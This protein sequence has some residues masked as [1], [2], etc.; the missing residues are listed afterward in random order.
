MQRKVFLNKTPKSGGTHSYPRLLLWAALGLMVLV[1]LTPLLTRKPSHKTAARHPAATH[2]GTVFAKI[3]KASSKE[4][5]ESANQAMQLA[6]MKPPV[7]QQQQDA[8]QAEPAPA[9]TSQQAEGSTANAGGQAAA[10]MSA[11]QP[12]PE[13]SPAPVSSSAERA[14]DGSADRTTTAPAAAADEKQPVKVA[15]SDAAAPAPP[16]PA[17]G[18]PAAAAA[19]LQAAQKAPGQATPSKPSASLQQS[20]P[21]KPAAPAG[22]W[23]YIVRVGSFSNMKN[24]ERLQKTLEKKGYD[25]V[26]KPYRHP[27][28]GLL[29]LVELEPIRK[30][31]IARSMMGAIKKT[32]HDKPMLIKVREGQ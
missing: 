1:L 19:A 6:G 20:A 9:A 24:A 10:Q 18:K 4:A 3:P 31:E 27:T 32:T 13:V 21:V 29:H 15:S 25:V 30:L 26:I 7:Q 17:A 8:Q 23:E 2:K 22:G 12:A 11:E 14:G 28:L 16:A 5:K